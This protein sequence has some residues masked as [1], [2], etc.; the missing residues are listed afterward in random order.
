MRMKYKISPF[1]KMF[2]LFIISSSPC[3]TFA[4]TQPTNEVLHDVTVRGNHPRTEGIWTQ[5]EGLDTALRG[6]VILT[7]VI[8]PTSQFYNWEGKPVPAHDLINQN[9]ENYDSVHNHY[10]N[11]L[12]EVWNFKPNTNAVSIWGDS[13]A[14]AK[15]AKAWGAFFSARSYY[16]AFVEGGKYKDLAPAGTDFSFNPND[17]DNQLVGVEIDVLNGGKPGVYPN[18]SKVGLQIVGFGNPNS[19]AVEIRSEDTDKDIPAEKRRGI[20]ESG[21]YFKNSL[22]S[23][24]RLIVADFDNAKMGFDFR[25]SLFR[26]GI[27]Q[28]RS[29]GVGTGIILNGGKSG[30]I[31]GGTRWDN[32]ANK[33]NWISIR[34]GQGG[35]RI[36]TN[37]NT[38][39]ILAVDN[40]NGIYINGDVYINGKKINDLLALDERI[41]KIEQQLATLKK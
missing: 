18:K 23:Y 15:D 17:Y 8:E 32:T 7:D 33:Q 26:E 30:E 28:A 11:F 40:N 31:Y 10:Q 2:F 9:A 20:W 12:S 36:V 34:N 21:L 37:D 5:Y 1:Y 6:H 3:N 25:R 19:M 24:G 16:K 41:S 35:T 27:M 14:I 38:K 22:A 4:D 29:E 39:E 13:A